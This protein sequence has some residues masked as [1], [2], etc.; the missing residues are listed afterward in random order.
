MTERKS[1][2]NGHKQKSLKSLVGTFQ[3]FLFIHR[4]SDI[5]IYDIL[6]C[7]CFSWIVFP[8]LSNVTMLEIGAHSTPSKPFEPRHT[9]IAVMFIL[10]CC[11][12]FLQFLNRPQ[13]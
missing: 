12:S 3:R 11:I 13:R 4:N 2:T 9:F 1:V 10:F 7:V 6:V 8:I 5:C